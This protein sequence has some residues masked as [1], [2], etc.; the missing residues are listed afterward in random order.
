[1]VDIDLALAH[2]IAAEG[3]RVAAK[4]KRF[5]VEAWN[6]MRQDSSSLRFILALLIATH[7][8]RV[9]E[10]QLTA[11]LALQKPVLG[12][13]TRSFMRLTKII[14]E[15]SRFRDGEGSVGLGLGLGKP[16]LKVAVGGS[17][18]TS[19]NGSSC[20]LLPT[21]TLFEGGHDVWDVLYAAAGQVARMKINEASSKM[22][23]HNRRVLDVLGAEDSLKM[24][25]FRSSDS[26]KFPRLFSSSLLLL[27]FPLL[28][29]FSVHCPT[30]A[31]GLGRGPLPRAAHRLLGGGGDGNPVEEVRLLWVVV[32]PGEARDGRF[33]RA[34]EVRRHWLSGEV[35]ARWGGMVGFYL[36]GGGGGGY[37]ARGGGKRVASRGECV[38]GGGGGGCVPG[39]AVG[40][41]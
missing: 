25:G 9:L 19:L 1:M 4:G 5:A 13:A 32:D 17:V 31:A 26:H 11:S 35:E 10:R 24:K 12:R 30:A 21:T 7:I 40:E 6:A 2:R 14:W 39:V 27:S 37:I 18:D 23:F 36:G 41:F 3:K 8:A 20:A 15:V 16:R 22:D 28:F 38:A 29:S 34:V 33:E